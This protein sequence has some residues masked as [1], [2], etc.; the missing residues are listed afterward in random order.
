MLQKVNEAV[1]NFR[2]VADQQMAET[3][4]RAIRENMVIT[5]QLKKM[6]TKT[7]EL[8]Q[9][10]DDLVKKVTRLKT[11]NV[12]LVENEKELAKKSQASQRVVKM[13]VEKLKE[14]DKMLEMAYDVY[15]LQE[16]QLEDHQQGRPIGG[17]A[18]MDEEQQAFDFQI[19]LQQATETAS[20]AVNQA[21]MQNLA[22]RNQNL[23]QK[24]VE[25]HRWIEDAVQFLDVERDETGS[26]DNTDDSPMASASTATLPEHSIAAD[27]KKMR[28]ELLTSRAKQIKELI[29]AAASAVDNV[30]AEVDEEQVQQD[31]TRQVAQQGETT[32]IQIFTPEE[33]SQIAS[34]DD[35]N[36][37]SLRPTSAPHSPKPSNTTM[38]S[39][40]HTPHQARLV[41]AVKSSTKSPKR[42]PELSRKTLLKN[43]QTESATQ[44]SNITKTTKVS[45]YTIKKNRGVI[46]PADLA[47]IPKHLTT[48]K[49]TLESNYNEVEQ[50]IES[51]VANDA[52]Q[53][54]DASRTVGT[55][56]RVAMGVS[57]GLFY[58]CNLTHSEN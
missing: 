28:I 1:S 26:N 44:P 10:N 6:S 42:S 23:Q 40:I 17:G 27:L 32:N 15:Q 58:S 57:F 55:Q 9:Q 50:V 2:R 12:L 52:A 29:D 39:T 8:I 4:K 54:D 14:S 53:F 20:E 37:N 51:Q 7:V 25:C 46:E 36:S 49:I 48:A 47:Q 13:L 33:T 24:L 31:Y 11:M 3:T 19:R 56:T 34:L 21:N 43:T 35:Q 41:S 22:L 5:T 30:L 16:A 38:H 45:N 18:F